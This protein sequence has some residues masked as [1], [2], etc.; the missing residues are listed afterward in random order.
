MIFALSSQAKGRVERMAETFQDRLVTELR[1]AGTSSIGKP[2][3]CWSSSYHGS[4][5]VSGFP[6]NSLNRHSGLWTRTC[7]WN[8]SCA[9]STPGGWPR[10][11]R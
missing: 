10:T 11:I 5:G 1:L 9:S 2:T 6:R 8:K 7:A 4:I 3:T